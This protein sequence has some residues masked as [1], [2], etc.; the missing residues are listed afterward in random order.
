MSTQI[1]PV[2]LLAQ[3]AERLGADCDR[4]VFVGGTT[5]SLLVADPAIAATRVTDDVDCIVHVEKLSEYYDFVHRLERTGFSPDINGPICRYEIGGLKVDIM[6]T[7]PGVLGFSNRWYREGL[8]N[9]VE[10]QLPNGAVVRILTAPFFIASKLE[11]FRG[12][13]E[14]DYW[15]SHDLEDMITVI[16]GRPAIVDEV[17]ASKSQDL[18]KYLAEQMAV[19]IANEKFLEALPGHLAPD[20][21]SQARKQIVLSRMQQIAKTQ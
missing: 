12:R 17:R 9:A 8:E 16:D 10:V 13:G 14:E 4:V 1:Q 2:D 21:A 7:Q 20:A 15:A 6:P 5:V 18:K 19:L 3:V 11:A